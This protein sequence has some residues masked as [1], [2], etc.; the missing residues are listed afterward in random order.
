MSL[1]LASRSRDPNTG[2]PAQALKAEDLFAVSKISFE[3]APVEA[4]VHV[5][6]IIQTVRPDQSDQRRQKSL[7]SLSTID[8]VCA[9]LP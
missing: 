9:P 6:Q 2:S 4:I 1:T 3:N 7:G 5:I 8:V